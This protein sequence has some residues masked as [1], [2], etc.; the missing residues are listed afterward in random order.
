MHNSLDDK[1]ISLILKRCLN[2]L[3]SYCGGFSIKESR[4]KM[5]EISKEIDKNYLN[6]AR[7]PKLSRYS[8]YAPVSQ[9]Q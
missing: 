8:R 1:E 5:L 6:E 2:K 7:Q 9:S 4:Q 3:D